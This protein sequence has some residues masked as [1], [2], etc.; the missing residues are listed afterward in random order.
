MTRR[1]WGRGQ[2][3]TL[4]E[5]IIAASILSVVAVTILGGLLYSMTES[6]RGFNRAQAA[7]WVQSE[8]DFLR[9]Q[10]YGVPLGTRRIPDT[11]NPANDPV[12][13]YLPNYGNLM[14]PRI[15][16]GFF[17]GEIITTAPFAG[18]PVN[19][20]TVRLYQTSTS[21]PYTILATYVS[22]FDYP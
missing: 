12:T 3:F 9:T 7:A 6:R 4:L 13:G 15:P 1:R 5:V 22:Q 18:L 20:L 10:G 19:Q 2:G 8:L 11:A 14:E 17:Q 21:P 16:P